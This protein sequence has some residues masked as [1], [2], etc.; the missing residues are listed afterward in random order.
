MP[1]ENTLLGTFTRNG[2]MNTMIGHEAG[3]MNEGGCGNVFVGRSAALE[4]RVGTNNVVVGLDAG[5]MN[6]EGNI[7]TYVGFRAGF[8]NTGH[9]NV[10]IGSFSGNNRSDGVIAIGNCTGA[11][12][13]SSAN[14]S[15]CIGHGAKAAHPNTIVLSAAG[16]MNTTQPGGLFVKPIRCQAAQGVPPKCLWYNQETGEICFAPDL[17]QAQPQ[18]QPRGKQLTFEPTYT[19]KVFTTFLINDTWNNWEAP[20][21]V[22]SGESVT[23]QRNIPVGATK[24]KLIVLGSGDDASDAFEV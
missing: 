2:D 17:P 4:N 21:D 3:M 1:I 24:V 6:T 14:G 19:G 16:R 11:A 7:N 8:D 10:A 9:N 18:E 20:F 23:V 5:R 12:G 22:V 13:D 15:V